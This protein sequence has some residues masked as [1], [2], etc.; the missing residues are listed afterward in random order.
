MVGII[1]RYALI[2]G[3]LTRYAIQ[4]ISALFLTKAFVSS[5]CS[6][7]GLI[8]VSLDLVTLAKIDLNSSASCRTILS[9]SALHS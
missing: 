8:I 6:L 4:M 3:A 1:M 7:T 9:F 5:M 2:S